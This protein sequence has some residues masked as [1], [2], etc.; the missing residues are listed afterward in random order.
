M[1]RAGSP[2]GDATGIVRVVSR[3]DRVQGGIAAPHPAEGRYADGFGPVAR[4]F[5]AHLRT[6][7][8]I[9]AAFSVFHRGRCVVD[10]WGGTADV[11][12]SLPWTHET[13]AMV[14]SVTKG[15]S[16][17][18]L[19]WLGERGVLDW[20]APVA[21]HWPEFA[22]AGKGAITVRTLFNHR[23]GLV[24]LDAPFTMEEC[25]ARPPRLLAALA[26][27]R[28]L[29]TPGTAQA[30]HA[31]T[32]GMYAQ[33]LVE[34][35]TGETIGRLLQRE[36][37]GPLGADVSLGTADGVAPMARLYPPSTF[38]RVRNT[39]LSALLGPTTEVRVLRATLQRGSLQ[40][41]AF[42][43]PPGS[44]AT[45]DVPAVRRAELAWASA[46]A[47][48]YGLARAYVPF[49]MGGEAF[50]RRYLRPATLAPLHAR[51]SWSELD[52]V[53]SKPIGWSQGFLK[54]E[55]S[56]FS[57]NPESFGHAGMGGALGWCDPTRELSYGY[58]MNRLDWQVRSPRA[59]ALARSIYDCDPVR[60]S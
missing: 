40:R 38:A 10:L 25:I 1:R 26:A 39:L 46:T 37:F 15:L 34:R 6:G 27:Q 9:G 33:A 49:A 7:R 32:F 13:R 11:E 2:G 45:Y 28:P 52:G 22:A 29:W 20:D 57:P 8:E 53:L 47:S 59:I 19:A 12:R 50:G 3:P 5:A 16:A 36:F 21:Q 18:A 55:T 44:P 14:F 51:Q 56:L 31:V 60:A 17:M 24:A 23:A 43:N 30:Y 48:A 58:V 35:L 41:R 54:D 42:T 4:T